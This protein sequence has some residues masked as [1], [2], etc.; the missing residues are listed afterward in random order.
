MRI[1]FSNFQLV[2]NDPAGKT[3]PHKKFEIPDCLQLCDKRQNIKF[4]IVY[5]SY[6]ARGQILASVMDKW[7]PISLK[8]KE[9]CEGTIRKN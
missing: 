5:L 7:Q 9:K 8:S 2:P 4:Y 1:Q 6:E 3:N